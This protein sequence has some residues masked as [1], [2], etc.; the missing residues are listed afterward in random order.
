[1]CNFKSPGLRR[2]SAVCGGH[3]RSVFAAACLAK[4]R[5][6]A[7]AGRCSAVLHTCVK[8]SVQAVKPDVC[9][10]AALKKKHISSYTISTRDVLIGRPDSVAMSCVFPWQAW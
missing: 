1:M 3:G 6:L 7:T 4:S 9:R 8:G 2:P 10:C 5:F